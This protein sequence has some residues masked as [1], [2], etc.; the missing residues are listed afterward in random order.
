MSHQSTASN[1]IPTGDELAATLADFDARYGKSPELAA[2]QAELADIFLM[3]EDLTLEDLAASE[4][5]LRESLFTVGRMAGLDDQAIEIDWQRI[6]L[7]S[8]FAD[9]HIEQL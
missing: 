8:Q 9:I 7:E 6:K 2:A 4:Q 3:E 5:M 1:T